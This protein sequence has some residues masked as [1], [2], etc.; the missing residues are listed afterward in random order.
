VLPSNGGELLYRIKSKHETY[1]RVVAED[2]LSSR[3][4]TS[5]LSN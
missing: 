4:A 3:G 1:E 2:Q 5:F